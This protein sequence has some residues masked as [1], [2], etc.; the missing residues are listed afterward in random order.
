[1]PSLLPS[2][3]VHLN[4]PSLLPL[5]A[6]PRPRVLRPRPRRALHTQATLHVLLERRE[7][8]ALTPDELEVYETPDGILSSE[9]VPAGVYV[10]EVVASKN[11]RKPRGRFKVGRGVRVCARARARVCV[12]GGG[13]SAWAVLL[14]WGVG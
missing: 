13:V 5:P 4:T 9:R 10:P 3:V 1:M 8:D 2:P 11:V 6:P 14:C 7:L 12:F